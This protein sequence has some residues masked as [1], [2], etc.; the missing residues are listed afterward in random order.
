MSRCAMLRRLCSVPLMRDGP[1]CL[2]MHVPAEVYDCG[3]VAIEHGRT[4]LKSL[5]S[6]RKLIC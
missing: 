3:M 6:C 1:A 5:E 4:M 2:A